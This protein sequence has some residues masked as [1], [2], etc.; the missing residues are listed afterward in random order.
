MSMSAS[1]CLS[2]SAIALFATAALM[3]SGCSS[4]KPETA[5]EVVVSEGYARALKLYEK[6]EYQA[7]AIGLEPLQFTARATALEDDVL[8]LLGQSYYHTDQYLLAAETFSRLQQQMPTSPFARA[9]QFMV[10]KSYEQLSP[11]VDLDQQPTRQAIENFALYMDIYPMA[12]SS[13]LSSDVQ[14]YRELLKINPNNDS[15][16]QNYSAATAK[17]ARID[18]LKYAEKAITVLREKLAKNSYTV[19]NQYVKLGKHKAAIV[20][21]DDVLDKYGDTPYGKLAMEGKIAMLVK[22]EKWFDAGAT[23]DQYLKRFPE[24]SKDMQ[25]LKEKIAQHSKI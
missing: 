2:R 18:S 20:F 17:Y 6:R 12:D 25:S 22:R 10:A 7:A 5:V 13:K 23:L 19:A 16:K 1:K 11:S 9:A 8:Y 14:T 24:K 21:Y 3:S 15:Y 4:S